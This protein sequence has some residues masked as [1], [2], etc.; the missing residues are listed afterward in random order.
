MLY[1]N[2]PAQ[3]NAAP[4]MN[5]APTSTNNRTVWALAG[6]MIISNLSV[7]LV[8]AVDTAVV[9]HLPAPHYIGA[10]A[11]GAVIFS[12]LY[13][14]FGFL[15]MGS[16]GFIARAYGANDETA[17]SQI[18]LRFLMLGLL[19]G[20]VIILFGSP[21]IRFALYCIDST[22]KVETLA[23]QYAHIRI[24]S[25][26][27]TL[28]IYVFTGIFIGL[29]KTRLAL[30]LQLVLNLTNIALDLL[31]VPVLELG[32][33]GVAW[34]TLIA[35][36]TAAVCGFMLLRKTLTR[37]LK[38]ADWK[39]ILEAGVV[40]EMMRSNG[41]IFIRTLC[42]VFSFAF[43]TAQSARHGELVLAANT[44]LIHLQS[45]MAYGLDGFAF[46][47]EALGGSAYGAKNLSNF[48]RAVSRTTMWSASMAF[49]I[50]VGYFLF[51]HTILSWF[52]EISEV[53]AIA[54]QYLV[55]MVISPIVSFL[56]FQLDGL[57]IGTGHTRSMRNAMVISTIGY[58]LLAYLFQVIWGNHGLFL[59]LACFMI[60]RAITLLLYYP[61]IVRSIEKNS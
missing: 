5:Q 20:L 47:A 52:T 55:W 58:L 45:I 33:A 36:Y 8:G 37:A 1:C 2:L 39:Q 11:L 10:V 3:S 15:R 27:A 43:F 13:W 38:T 46:A 42:L 7:P 48:K 18:M 29:H 35:E 56:S 40:K 60:L 22:D 12:F 31:F 34:A 59:A 14:G 21:L 4:T 6:P 32:V 57:F 16:T 50:S 19:L 61:H 28:C 17:L 24:W 54:N 44:I 30:V 49:T 41:N 25:A 53:I 9:G 23:Q 51:G 26:P